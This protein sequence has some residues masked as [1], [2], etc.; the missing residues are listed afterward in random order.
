MHPERHPE[1]QRL[2][3]ANHLQRPMLLNLVAQYWLDSSPNV[4]AP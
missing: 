1:Q 2:R 3:L 4:P